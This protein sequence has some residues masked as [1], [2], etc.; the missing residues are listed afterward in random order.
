MN[1][2]ETI[3]DLLKQLTPDVLLQIALIL[4]TAWL[5]I[6]AIEKTLPWLADRIAGRHRPFLMAS[7]PA[8]RL[9]VIVLSVVLIAL[10]AIPPSF[11]HIVA[12]LTTLGIALGFAFKDYLSSLIAGVVTLYEMPYVM[13]DWVEIDGVYGEVKAIRMRVVELLTPDDTVVMIPHL[14]LWKR[15]I[16]NT[17]DGSQKL[18]C[19]AD[20]HLHPRHDAERVRHALAEVALASPFLRIQTP[21]VVIVAEKPWGTHYRLKAYPVEPR[22]QFLFTTDLT[23]RGKA[24]LTRMGVEFAATLSA[25]PGSGA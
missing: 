21:V 7:V 16:H 15:P 2:S 14:A 23:V 13:G 4:A 11:E 18:M 20:F 5:F 8:L 10:K 19:V 6:L 12:V 22:H 3:A 9:A 25:P 24:V 17:N 1:V